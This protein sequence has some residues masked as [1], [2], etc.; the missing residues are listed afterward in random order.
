MAYMSSVTVRTPRR[1][2]CASSCIATGCRI[3]GSTRTI[4]TISRSWQRWA[5]DRLSFRVIAW[6]RKVLLQNPSLPV[7]ADFCGIHRSIPKDVFDTVIIGGG[8]AGLGAAVYAASEGLHTLVLDRLGPG[9]Q[10]GSSSRIENYAGFPPGVSGNELALRS[11]LQALK[12]GSNLFDAM[13]RGGNSS[14]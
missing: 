11:Y 13:R 4:K 2:D 10:A 14:R 5:K 7:F 6:S 9:G 8:P 3:A 1:F 12:F